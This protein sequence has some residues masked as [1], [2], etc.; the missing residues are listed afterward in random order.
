MNEFKKKIS[1]IMRD[2]KKLWINN[3]IKAKE[4]GKKVNTSAIMLGETEIQHKLDLEIINLEAR[5]NKGKKKGL[6][7]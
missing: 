4:E 2:Y 5:L 3:I 7:G 6:L 1:E